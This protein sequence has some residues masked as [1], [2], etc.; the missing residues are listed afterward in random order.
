VKLQDG[1]LAALA[2]DTVFTISKDKFSTKKTSRSLSEHIAVELSDETD[3][4][5]VSGRQFPGAKKIFSLHNLDTT[6]FP[7]KDKNYVLL[8]RKSSN[9]FADVIDIDSMSVVN[10]FDSPHAF[11]EINSVEVASGTDLLITSGDDNKIT[12][13][14]A[15]ENTYGYA[16]IVQKFQY[17]HSVLRAVHIPGTTTFA[18][19]FYQKYQDSPKNLIIQHFCAVKN[20]ME[21]SDLKVCDACTQGLV[22]D[23]ESNTCTSQPIL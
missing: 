22:Y 2:G 5:L 21:C 3:E 14:K 9:V 16:K 8:V 1:S 6:S 18:A 4:S 19:T 23:Q 17:N 10:S 20:C 11:F 12:V 15:F 13:I 7:N